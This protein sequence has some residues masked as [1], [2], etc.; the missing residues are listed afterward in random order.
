[1]RARG[2]FREETMSF[3][4]HDH[5]LI[6]LLSFPKGTA[7]GIPGVI[8][9]H[10]FTSDRDEVPIAGS[11]ETMFQRAAKQLSGVGYATLRF[12]FYGHG[13]SDGRFEELTLDTLIDDASAAVAHLASRPGVAS[14]R[15][16][17]LGQ[18]LGGLVAACTANRDSRIRAIALWNAP[19]HPLYSFTMVLGPESMR[20][21]LAE[22]AVEFTWEDKGSFKL[23]RTFFDSLSRTSPL[24]EISKFK[25]SLLAIVGKEDEHIYPQPL[26]GEAF[27]HAHPGSHELYTFDADH[28]FTVSSRGTE[29]LDRAIHLTMDWLRRVL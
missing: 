18:S 23:N 2:F 28:I 16:A 9:L 20:A 21:A 3:Q 12:D 22:G 15:I 8:F 13:E 1:M 17:L 11:E 26:M 10:G 19:S 7:E 27:I 6:G 24:V 4:S 25:G 29:L 5:T 14:D